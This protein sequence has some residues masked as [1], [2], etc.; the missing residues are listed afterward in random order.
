MIVSFWGILEMNKY[1]NKWSVI[2]FVVFTLFHDYY[3]S[4]FNRLLEIGIIGSG[5]LR[6][7]RNISKNTFLT[8]KWCTFLLPRGPR[9]WTRLRFRIFPRPA[10]K[11]REDLTRS[12][13]SQAPTFLRT[14]TASL[15]F[16]KDW[17]ESSTTR[18]NS[19]TFSTEWP[20]IFN[21]NNDLIWVFSGSM[22]FC[23]FIEITLGHGESGDGG[24]SNGRASGIT[25]LGHVDLNFHKNRHKLRST[26][27]NKYKL[28]LLTQ[29]Y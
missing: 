23:C 24:S 25:S 11:R 28:T 29:L 9:F 27:I 2:R 14:P 19:G 7:K 22:Y 4:F 6:F 13:S 21:K 8:R 16:F 15:V 5:L 26:E 18:G 1:Q 17:T 3:S 20:I 12:T 10:L